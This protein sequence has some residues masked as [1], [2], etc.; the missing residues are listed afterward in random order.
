MKCRSLFFSSI[1]VLSWK[2]TKR[3][4]SLARSRVVETSVAIVR[5]QLNAMKTKLNDSLVIQRLFGRDSFHAMAMTD[6]F[7]GRGDWRRR[8]R[9]RG[10]VVSFVFFIVIDFVDV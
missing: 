6:W 8:R 9:E 4:G 2:N 10:V 3:V 7:R 1:Y 5:G